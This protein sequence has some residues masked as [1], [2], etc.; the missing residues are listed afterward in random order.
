YLHDA[1]PI[2]LRIK[3]KMFLLISIVLIVFSVG[4]ISIL[5]YAFHIYND[6]IYRQSAQSLNVSSIS[7]ENELKKM[8]R[9]SYQVA[10]DQAIQDYLV[11]LNESEREFDRFLISTKLRNHL[12]QVGALNKYVESIQVYDLNDNEYKAG[13]HMVVLPQDALE[14]MT[15]KAREKEGSAKWMPA[16]DND[17]AFAVTRDVR[18]YRTLTLE[19]LGIIIFRIYMDEIINDIKGHS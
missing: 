4:G 17:D 12:T 3:Y 10:T 8:E 19:H 6:E 16:H 11:D 5:K 14:D 13:N 15:Q 9:L 18:Y 1:L 7:I 2:Y